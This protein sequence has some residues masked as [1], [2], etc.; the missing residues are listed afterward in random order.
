MSDGDP[1]PHDYAAILEVV[2]NAWRE[3]APRDTFALDRELGDTGIDSLKAMELV[4]RLERQLGRKISYGLLSPVTT[5]VSLATGIAHEAGG[6]PAVPGGRPS[7]FFMTGLGGH[8]LRMVHAWQ[9]KLPQ[10]AFIL[11]DAPGL[12]QPRS[13]LTD[14]KATA[15]QVADD[16]AQRQPEGDIRLAGYSFGGAL[17]YEVAGHLI[18]RG[19]RIA[20]L[21]LIDVFPPHGVL[22]R[23]FNALRSPQVLRRRLKNRVPGLRR[24]DRLTDNHSLLMDAAIRMDAWALASRLARSD[25]SPSAN[26]IA[27][28]RLALHHLRLQSIRYWRPAALDVPV[29]LVVTSDGVTARAPDF[30]SKLCADLRVVEVEG[31]HQNLAAGPAADGLVESFE[32]ALR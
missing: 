7:L 23:L 14:L 29:L 17:A 31:T 27:A 28:D 3:T 8:Q 32:R 26:M 5:P 25:R 16:I 21:G 6:V 19:R 11:V 9:A 22:R 24:Q 2:S 20:F 15:L 30:W 10:F 12:D 4:L 1:G 13:V 18:A